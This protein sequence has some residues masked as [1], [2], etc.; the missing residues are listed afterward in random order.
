MCDERFCSLCAVADETVVKFFDLRCF[1]TLA[2]DLVN[3]DGVNGFLFKVLLAL[4]VVV[5]RDASAKC[6]C[7]VVRECCGYNGW[8]NEARS[9]ES[10]IASDEEILVF[11]EDECEMSVA[12]T[13]TCCFHGSRDLGYLLF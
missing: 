8:Y 10:H 9:H 2:N 4:K 3:D 1:E 7:C 13:P 11:I 12:S 5:S 6:E